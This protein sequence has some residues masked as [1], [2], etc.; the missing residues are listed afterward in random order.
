MLNRKKSLFSYCFFF[1]IYI[2]SFAALKLYA[3]EHYLSEKQVDS[4][5]S[6]VIVLGE[7]LVKERNNVVSGL[8]VRR[9]VKSDT[10]EQ[11][12]VEREVDRR[13][14]K[15]LAGVTPQYPYFSE[16]QKRP[17][18]L[19]TGSSSEDGSSSNSSSAEDLTKARGAS[20][21]EESWQ[22][23]R[24]SDVS[25][26]E[27]TSS[28]DARWAA[29]PLDG[30]KDY[31]QG[32]RDY[33]AIMLSLI[34]PLGEPVFG[35]IHFPALRETYWGG[36]GIEGGNKAVYIDK[37]NKEH[38]LIK[39]NFNIQAPRYA[40]PYET[41]GM[42]RHNDF[43][44][45]HLNT[46]FFENLNKSTESGALKYAAVI[47][48]NC[49]FYPRLSAKWD[50]QNDKT[51]GLLLYDIAPFDGIL[52]AIGGGVYGEN[53]ELYAYDYNFEVIKLRDILALCDQNAFDPH[54]RA[55]FNIGILKHLGHQAQ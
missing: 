14:K 20:A 42:D 51:W 52:R 41:K 25:E 23:V 1:L 39:N 4:I 18:E 45:T 35:I 31:R 53:G 36:T 28:L 29:D 21:A 30:T 19:S 13:L 48:G 43:V 11:I 10:S 24:K 33:Y 47:K 46:Y 55:I 12:R 34:N 15:M 50:D 27:Q 32:K 7:Y 37:M 5:K 3:D 2:L 49:H 17:G 8:D 9:K 6:V 54:F 26:I 16:E 38:I 22:I 44:E 40:A